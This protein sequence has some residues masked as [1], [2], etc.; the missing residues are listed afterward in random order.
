MGGR[1]WGG[2]DGKGRREGGLGRGVFVSYVWN[3]FINRQHTA[4]H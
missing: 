3:T 4:G 2:E 1:W